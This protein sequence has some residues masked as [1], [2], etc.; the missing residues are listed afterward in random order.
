MA[1]DNRDLWNRLPGQ[2]INKKSLKKHVRRVEGAT[3]RH[4]HKFLIKRLD[5]VREVQKDVIVWVL[6][7]GFLIAATGLQLIWNQQN[8]LTAAPSDNGTYAEAVMGP[9]ETLNP[10]YAKSSAE[11][12]IGHLIFSRLLDY[13]T[14]GHL[15]YDLAS[16]IKINDTKTVYTVSIKDNV[17]WQDGAKLT[18]KDVAFTVNLMK[19]SNA[20]TNKTGWSNISTKLI[21]DYTIEFTLGSVFAPFEQALVFPVL[22]EHILGK[23]APGNIR[24]NDFSKNPI[25]SGPFQL[26]FVQ[27]VNEKSNRKVVYMARND[28]YYLGKARLSRF[29][30]HVY[31]SEDEIVDALSK[32]E[33]TAAAGISFTNIDKVDAKRYEVISKP[34]Q[35]GM[36]AIINT[37]SKLLNNLK[38]RQALRLATDTAFIRKELPNYA[39]ALWLPITN[40][41]LSG[42]LPS[43]PRFDLSAAKQLLDKEGWKLGKDNIREKKGQQLKFS[44]VT[45]KNSEYEHVLDIL[46]GQ[47]RALGVAVSTKI[48]DLNDPTSGDVQSVLQP[49]NYDVL[50]YELNIGGDPDVYAYW[51]S[52]QTGVQGLNFANYSN[53]VSDVALISARDQLEYEL[54][55]K[56]YLTFCKQWLDDI[57]AIGLYQPTSQYV[58]SRKAHAFDESTDLLVSPVER[59]TN[60]LD[61]SVGSVDVFKTP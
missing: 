11:N 7:L 57:P 21:D 10:L 54:R 51:H 3:I 14:T 6:A 22:P 37:Q 30:L 34:I 4:A 39:P 35:S 44:V 56:K 13:D 18:A 41:L 55:N 9:I 48:I 20:R 45:L 43:E 2:N 32:N 59:Y 38:L 5:N 47:W 26:S 29:Q 60:V 1:E 33:V 42:K 40:S 58:I 46:I 28:S 12:S 53:T 19:D 27:N 8:Y 16:N 25:G 50:L 23:V 52:S 49:R 36:Y 17:K 31:D 61:W 24:E 15:N